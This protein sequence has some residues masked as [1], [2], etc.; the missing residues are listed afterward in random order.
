MLLHIKSLSKSA[1]IILAA[2]VLFTHN[3]SAEKPQTAIQPVWE[4][5]NGEWKFNNTT[6][7]SYQSLVYVVT[8]TK[9]NSTK[10]ILTKEMIKLPFVLILDGHRKEGPSLH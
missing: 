9:N 10:S 4:K 1:A 3:A 5:I 6:K 8:T 2:L 7:N